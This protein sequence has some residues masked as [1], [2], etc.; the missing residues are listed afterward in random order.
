MLPSKQLQSLCD[1]PGFAIEP[2]TAQSV[3][4]DN[5]NV[6]YCIACILASHVKS[7]IHNYSTKKKQVMA[8]CSG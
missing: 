3:T 7:V 4:N 6:H 1:S 8:S 5:D 2:C